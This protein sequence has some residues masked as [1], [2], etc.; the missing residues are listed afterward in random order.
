MAGVL[1][2]DERIDLAVAS[3]P[4]QALIDSIK[5]DL[6]AD[7]LE[8]M[9]LARTSLPPRVVRGGNSNHR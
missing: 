8:D 2:V 6:L 7:Q 4:D 1:T 9:E 3:L 5:T